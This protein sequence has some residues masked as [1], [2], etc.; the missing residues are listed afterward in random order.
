[1]SGMTVHHL[2][3]RPYAETV[4]VFQ[5]PD[6]CCCLLKVQVQVQPQQ[7]QQQQIQEPTSQQQIVQQNTE[8]QIV[9][10]CILVYQRIITIPLTHLFSS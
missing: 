8:Q 5:A 6:T 10:V 3:E 4:P 7:Q 9:Q 2:Q 1:M